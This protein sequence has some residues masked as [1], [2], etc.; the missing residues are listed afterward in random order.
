MVIFDCMCHGE[1]KGTRARERERA[2]S[3]KHH[4]LCILMCVCEREK[5]REIESKWGREKP[6]SERDV[7]PAN[8]VAA[9]ILTCLSLV[10]FLASLA[11]IFAAVF[12]AC[13]FCSCVPQNLYTFTCIGRYSVQQGV[14]VYA[15]I[16][17]CICIYIYVKTYTYTHMH[18][19]TCANTHTHTENT[20]WIAGYNRWE[21][22]KM[23]Y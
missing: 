22:A 18:I 1:R 23:V 16:Y 2:A 14:A 12:A 9:S 20:E 6:C 4:S 13:A 8:A 17:M 3:G 5:D 7:V 19:H 15:F 21:R 11:L 10:F